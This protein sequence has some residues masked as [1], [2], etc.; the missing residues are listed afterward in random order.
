[1]LNDLSGLFCALM[2][3]IVFNSPK[4]DTV[5]QSQ[6]KDTNVEDMH[7]AMCVAQLLVKIKLLASLRFLRL[8]AST[9]S[10]NQLLDP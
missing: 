9:E 3:L 2:R 8:I 10:A 6:H 7:C 1:M 4:Q 5:P